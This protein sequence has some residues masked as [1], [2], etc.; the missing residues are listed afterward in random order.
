MIG[1]EHEREVRPA[2]RQR[3]M[4]EVQQT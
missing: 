4:T 1:F 2:H 3:P